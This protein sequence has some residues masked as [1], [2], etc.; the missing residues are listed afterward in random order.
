VVTD[1][2]MPAISDP[3]FAVVRAAVEAGIPVR[4][5]PGASAV[6]AALAVSGLPSD[7][8]AF[9]GFLPRSGRAR[10]ERVAALRAEPRTVVLFESA[11]RILTTVEELREGLGERPVV[12]CRELTKLH[13][14]VLRGTL[15]EVAQ[16]LRQRGN[17]KGE[18]VVVLAGA[19]PETTPVEDAVALARELEA[20]GMRKRDAAREVAAR[21]GASAREIYEHLVGP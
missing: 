11:R 13:E 3:G 20:G 4:V 6:T 15:G 18:V 10:R 14:E 7:R 9:D 16:E 19:A 5:V 2:G 21:T 8:F 1:A 17:V 12:V